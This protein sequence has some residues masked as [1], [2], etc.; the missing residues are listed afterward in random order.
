MIAQ[1][2]KS[3]SER[4][5]RCRLRRSHTRKWDQQGQLHYRAAGVYLHFS[6]LARPSTA[7]DGHIGCLG[8]RG[9]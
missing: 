6:R 3:N 2:L 1:G 8:T 4:G 9:A 7:A 5:V